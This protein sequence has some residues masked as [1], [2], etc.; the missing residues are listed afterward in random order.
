V[1][2]F[3]RLQR[4]PDY[5]QRYYAFFATEAPKLRAQFAGAPPKL[6]EYDDGIVAWATDFPTM[7][8]TG[9]GL[10]P[11]AARA[12]QRGDLLK[13]ASARGYDH[14]T[15]LVYFG[16]VGLPPEPTPEELA[17]WGR[18]NRQAGDLTNWRLTQTWR[19]EDTPFVIVRFQPK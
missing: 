7:S 12:L 9:L 13:I 16:A 2:F 15:S 17:R 18:G 8:A 14:L 5:H 1:G 3:L 11:E 19:S 10:D 4:H 6:L